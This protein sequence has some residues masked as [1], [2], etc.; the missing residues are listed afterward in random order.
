MNEIFRLLDKKAPY[1]EEWKSVDDAEEEYDVTE[2]IIEELDD[3]QKVPVKIPE[4]TVAA[5]EKWTL[6]YEEEL[7]ILFHNYLPIHCDCTVNVAIGI[8]VGRPRLIELTP[9]MKWR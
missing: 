6:K 7:I 3:G 2:D 1:S 4:E 8:Y 9:M 5:R